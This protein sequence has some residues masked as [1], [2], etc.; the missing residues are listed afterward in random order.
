MHFSRFFCTSKIGFVIVTSILQLDDKYVPLQTRNMNEKWAV[1]RPILLKNTIRYAII[2]HKSL[3]CP[4]KCR[5]FINKK[6]H[7]DIDELVLEAAVLGSP[8]SLHDLR[9]SDKWKSSVDPHP[10][11]RALVQADTSIQQSQ[12]PKILEELR[13]A[14]QRVVNS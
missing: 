8:F 4:S 6:S 5:D 10:H 1:S 13:D 11:L 12:P 7:K 14:C 2:S 9:T 3:P